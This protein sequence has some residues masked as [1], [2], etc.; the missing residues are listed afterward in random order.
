MNKQHSKL[1][2]EGDKV[3][4]LCDIHVNTDRRL[5]AD[6]SDLNVKDHQTGVCLL[7]DMN[8]TCDC[9]I[10][11]REFREI[12]KHKDMQTQIPPHKEKS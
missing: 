7:V 9:N 2:S 5:K 12:S 4:I 1:V 11:C 6:R 3:I 10:S 8:V